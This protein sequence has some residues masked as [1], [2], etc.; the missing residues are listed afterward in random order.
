MDEAVMSDCMWLLAASGAVMP[1]CPEGSAAARARVLRREDPALFPG[2]PT[3]GGAAF[4]AAPLLAGPAPAMEP[5]AG[6][7]VGDY[8]SVL[9]GGGA[10]CEGDACVSG[11]YVDYGWSAIDY[12]LSNDPARRFEQRLLSASDE[13]LQR[14][15]EVWLQG[16]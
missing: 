10:A 1:G 9:Y 4:A 5:A 16:C 15:R 6:G 7:V 11:D 14:V 13:W 8:E 12:E 3:E 2:I